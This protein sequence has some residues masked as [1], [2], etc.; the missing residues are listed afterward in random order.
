M[1]IVIAPDSYK[2]SLGAKEAAEAIKAGILHVLP[3]SRIVTMP[4]ADGG[5]GTLQCLVDAT[6]GKIHYSTVKNPVGQ[7]I[8]SPFGLL[9]DGITCV[10]ELAA[11]SGLYLIEKEQRNPLATTTY[12]FGQL[13]KAGLDKGCRRFILGLGGSATNDG[14]AGMLQA[15]GFDLL[16]QSNN[17]IGF[18]GG[19]LSRLERIEMERVDPRLAESTFVIACDVENPFVGLQG[20]SH[21][22]GPQK[23]ASPQVAE[24]LDQHLRRFADQIEQTKGIAIHDIPGTGAAGG[25]SGALLAFLGGTLRSGIEIV[26]ETTGLEQEIKDADLVF[27][28]EG[29]VDFQTAKGKTPYGVAKIAQKYGVPVILLTGSIGQ[30]IEALYEHGVTAI[31]SIVNKP[32]PLE[33]AMKQTAQLLSQSAE[34]VM[35]VYQIRGGSRSKLHLSRKTITE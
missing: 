7:E 33:E 35:R 2:G 24:Q 20:A 26:M 23:G 6:D 14:G 8:T 27:T 4:M 1:K 10:I 15:L 11:A 16:D 19:E 22:F 3:Q 32:L 21:V 18:G 31:F 12:G 29:Q 5:E 25:V 28:G 17:P 34:Q 13:I 9:G 30:G